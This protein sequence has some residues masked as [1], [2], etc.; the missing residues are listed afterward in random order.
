[1]RRRLLVGVAVL[2]LAAL[3]GCGEATELRLEPN[4]TVEG[5]IDDGGDRDYRVRL[6]AEVD[7]GKG[8]HTVS[9]ITVYGHDS[10]GEVICEGDVGSISTS[11]EIPFFE[12][13]RES[14]VTRCDSIPAF[15]SI[16]FSS[17]GGDTSPAPVR[18]RLSSAVYLGQGN[19]SRILGFQ[20][21]PGPH[22]YREGPTEEFRLGNPSHDKRSPVGESMANYAKCRQYV[23]D[24]DFSALPGDHPWTEGDP[25]GPTRETTYRIHVETVLPSEDEKDRYPELTDADLPDSVLSVV[26]A[27]RSGE[28]DPRDDY[29]EAA[30]NTTREGYL[31]AHRTL[32]GDSMDGPGDV[33][34]TDAEHWIA[35]TAD[36]GRIDCEERRYV[37]GELT[38]A[39]YTVRVGDVYWEVKVERRVALSGEVDVPTVDDGEE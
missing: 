23:A 3:A 36:D 21:S 19:G 10:D 24:G 25:A 38:W 7:S 1:M 18:F 34:T 12:D 5:T 9:G 37:G 17:I 8:E 4:A 26:E 33:P 31:A 20:V 2:A 16:D 28:G 22:R 14:A 39:V 32:S 6:V 13:N 29:V 11:N 35:G 30:A 27:A 15:L